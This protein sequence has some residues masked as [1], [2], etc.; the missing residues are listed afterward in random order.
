MK[1]RK[2]GDAFIMVLVGLYLAFLFPIMLCFGI[3][4]LMG[5]FRK[6]EATA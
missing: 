3:L 4:K 1:L 5:F 2:I 6:K